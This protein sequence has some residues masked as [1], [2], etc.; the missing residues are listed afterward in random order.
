MTKIIAVDPGL[1]TGVAVLCDG[2]HHSF[3]E[4]DFHDLAAFVYSQ[5]PDVIVCEAFVIRQNTHKLD[6]GAFSETTD[7]IGAMRL[8]AELAEVPFHR[9]TPAQAKS[10]ATDEK[11]RRLG[12]FNPTPGGHANDATRHLLIYLVGIKDQT[13]LKALTGG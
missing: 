2:V 9:Q 6:A 3:E 10:F 4:P 7:R 12:W 8:L 1:L 5:Q 11:L 13:T